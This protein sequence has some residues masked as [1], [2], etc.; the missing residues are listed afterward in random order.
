M[1]TEMKRRAFLAR[2]AGCAVGSAALS[3]A[4]AGVNV[5]PALSWALSTLQERG[6]TYAKL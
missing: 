2:V 5:V 6:F 4:A 3:R 1:P